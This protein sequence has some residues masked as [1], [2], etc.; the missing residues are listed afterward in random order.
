MSDTTVSRYKVVDVP[1]LAPGKCWVSKTTEGPFIDT[2]I[3]IGR[4]N[5]ERGRLYLS[6]ETIREM[7][8]TAGVL[9]EGPSVNAQLYAQEQF[10]KGY[11]EALKENYGDLIRNLSER[12]AAG[13]LDPVGAAGTGEAEISSAA[14]V[15]E[16]GDDENAGG[17][18]RQVANTGS[19]KR[20]SSVSTNTGDDAAF[21][22]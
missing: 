4:M 9:G 19:R 15:A 16:H 22:L 10:D 8:R 2:G 6:V 5:I 12:V 13:F 18:E 1:V 21:R 7:A 14:P 3:D 17:V 20:P 11:A